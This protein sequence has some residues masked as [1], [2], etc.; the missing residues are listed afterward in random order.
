MMKIFLKSFEMKKFMLLIGIVFI[1]FSCGGSDDGPDNTPTNPGGNTPVVPDDNFDTLVWS[2]EFDKNGS[3]DSE[4]WSYD[5][6]DGCPDLC[7]WGNNEKQYYTQRPEN[8]IVEDGI[9]KI[10][11]KKEEYEGLKYTSTRMLTKDKFE[12]TYGRVEVKAKLPSGGGTWPAI[13]MLGANIDLAGWPACGEIDI[14]EHAGNN[15]GEVSSALHTPSSFGATV[16]YGSQV[17]DDVSDEFHIYTVEWTSKKITFA[18]DGDIHLSYNPS[19]KN[20]NTWPFYADQFLIL[21][22]AMGGNV[23]GV[24]DTNFTES[25]MEIDYIRVYQ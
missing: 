8:V 23:G 24:I 1:S 16:N 11:V 10:K 22:I 3:P 25:A 19:N 7:G 18:V 5:I 20:S 21:N 13:W 14:M 4:K 9:L 6:G 2:D 17:L 12:F 15:Q